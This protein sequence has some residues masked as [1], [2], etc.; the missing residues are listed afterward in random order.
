M[1][2]WL[3]LMRLPNGL[4]AFMAV[5]LGAIL[6]TRSPVLSGM[7]IF[8][9]GLSTLLIAAGGNVL[10]DI[11]DIDIDRINRPDRP[12][13]AERITISQA[14]VFAMILDGVGLLLSYLI[15]WF[16]VGV[17]LIVIVL[18]SGYNIYWKRQPLIGNVVVAVC[19]ALCFIYGGLAVNAPLPAVIP[20]IFAFFFIWRGK[21][22]R[23]WKMWRVIGR[24]E[25]LRFPFILAKE[26]PFV[27]LLVF[28]Q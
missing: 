24:W 12:L 20:A 19:G 2:H 28:Y 4:I 16:A 3:Q 14:R 9:A 21:S 10:N 25:R 17:A 23:I 8:L 18:L 22:S 6:S 15:G 1:K 11:C 5:L 27:W 26:P 13:P 7:E